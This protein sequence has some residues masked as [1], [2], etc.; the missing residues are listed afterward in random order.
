LV[1]VGG[2]YYNLICQKSGKALDNSGSS[3]DGTIMKQ[4]TV[5]GG[6]NNQHW[7]FVSTGNGCYNIICQ[8]GGEDLDNGGSTTDGSAIKQWNVQGGNVN[9]QWRLKFIR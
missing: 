3:S 2:G 4:W 5:Q 8:V 9:Q 7:K 6:N 1:D